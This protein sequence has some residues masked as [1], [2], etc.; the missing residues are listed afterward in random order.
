[1]QAD[2]ERNGP[3]TL[4]CYLRSS[5]TARTALCLSVEVCHVKETTKATMFSERLVPEPA[6]HDEDKNPRLFII[7][8]LVLVCQTARPMARRSNTQSCVPD[9]SGDEQAAWPGSSP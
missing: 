8:E 3:R 7:L 1:M 5:V 6:S 9:C 4:Y 2:N